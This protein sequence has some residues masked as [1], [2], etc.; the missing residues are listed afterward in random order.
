VAVSESPVFLEAQRLAEEKARQ[1]GAVEKAHRHRAHP[2]QARGAGGDG[3]AHRENVA[4]YVITAF[5]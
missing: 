3:R 1:T 2:L 5:S 4:Y